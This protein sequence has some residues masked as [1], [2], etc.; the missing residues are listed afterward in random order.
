MDS[1][2]ARRRS[3]VAAAGA[4]GVALV[5]RAA[6]GARSVLLPEQV[7]PVEDLAREHGVLQRLLLVYEAIANRIESSEALPDDVLASSAG[8]V[9]RFIE[10][11]HE[12]MEETFVFPRFE[13]LEPFRDLVTTLHAQHDA[14]RRVTDD[15]LSLAAPHALDTAAAKMRLVADIHAYLR[16]YRPHAAREDTVI[17]P[18]LRALLGERVYAE[19]GD[20]LEE[21]EHRRFG[22]HGFE[23]AVAEVARLEQRLGIYDI[24]Q[25]TP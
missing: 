23:D 25:F 21:E 14:G 20:S 8:L 12:E 11:Y 4:T 19:L 1:T 15:I 16:M 3:F 24:A 9:R 13:A 2:G 10:E 5:A 7:S 17:F 18:G 6:L 22:A